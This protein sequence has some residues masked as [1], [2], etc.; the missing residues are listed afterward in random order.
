MTENLGCLL[1]RHIEDVSRIIFS[2]IQDFYNKSAPSALKT[3]SVVSYQSYVDLIRWNPHWHC[4]ILE[5]GIDE[6]GSFY[7]LHIKDTS[8]LT[9]VFRKRVIKLFV[10]KDL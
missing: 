8:Q 4:I 3:E 6:K 7:Y 9:E 2:I 5:G 1:R 10:S